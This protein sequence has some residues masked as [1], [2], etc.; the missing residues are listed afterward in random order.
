MKVYIYIGENGVG[1][2]LRPKMWSGRAGGGGRVGG[3][4]EK[5]TDVD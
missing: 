3:A 1:G 5:Q 4:K 2:Y